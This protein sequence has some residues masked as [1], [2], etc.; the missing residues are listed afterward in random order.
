MKRQMA[1][2]CLACLLGIL[3]GS[4]AAAFSPHSRDTR[5]ADNVCDKKID[6]AL[7]HAILNGVPIFDKVLQL[8]SSNRIDEARSIL[9]NYA[10][11]QLEDAWTIN[12]KYDRA[13]SNDLNSVLIRVYPR[14]RR[15]VD[16]GQFTNFPSDYLTEMSNFVRAAD[17]LTSAQAQ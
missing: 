6:I 15:E 5:P 16:F 4:C 13:L 12:R 14:L 2:L 7:G 3:V 9:R 1:F 8:A 17:S 11:W 10:W